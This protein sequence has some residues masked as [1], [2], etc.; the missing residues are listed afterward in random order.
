M[1]FDAN[2]LASIL[3][4]MRLVSEEQIQDT[5]EHIGFRTADPE[6]LLKTLENKGIV[7]P[8]QSSRIR[9]GEFADSKVG[10][11]RLLY[12]I[13]SGSFG[14]VYRA[15]E[16]QTGRVVAIKVLRRRWSEDEHIIDLFE[17][18]GKL[19]LKLHH[20]NIV[21]VLAVGQDPIT[22]SYYIVM[23]FVEGANLRDLIQI[24]QKLEP[25][26]AL[27]IIEDAVNGIAHAY[28]NGVTH[29]DMKLTNVLISSVGQVK[30]VDFGLAGIFVRKGLEMES[31]D[32]IDRT[33]E[34]A[35][36]E[37]ATGV[38][39]GDVRSDIYFLGCVLYEILTGR[40]PL[41]RTRDARA[42]ATSARLHGRRAHETRGSEWAASVFQLVEAMMS[43]DPR[44]RYQTPAQLLEAVKEVREQLTNPDAVMS[45]PAA[46][47]TIFVVE[48]DPRLQ[49]ALREK[50]K[51]QGHRVLISGD[52][53]RALVRLR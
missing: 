22:K 51:E 18:E 38:K 14:R 47:R 11:Y 42:C 1:E 13:A 31:I 49:N 28:A 37:K 40:S 33:V 34:Y 27:G 4:K 32:K 36:L 44:V 35:G 21:E 10:G 23:E 41:Q 30:L 15:E 12:K 17:R 24:Q 9:K 46:I 8:L 3:I 50:L 43:L 6:V 45:R 52:P 16:P 48:P 53:S 20:P 5:W 25:D 2:A 7:T 29:R 26:K 39:P 19:G